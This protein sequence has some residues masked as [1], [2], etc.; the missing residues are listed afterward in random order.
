MNKNIFWD[1]NYLNSTT[2]RPQGK[3]ILKADREIQIPEK[4]TIKHFITDY[5]RQLQDTT[6]I[7]FV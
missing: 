1:N 6:C 2:P 7:A 4:N 5:F 3:N